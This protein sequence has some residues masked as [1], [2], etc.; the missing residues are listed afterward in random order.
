MK[1]NDDKHLI[2]AYKDMSAYQ[3]PEEFM[4]IQ[5]VD[6]ARIGFMLDLCDG[7][8]KLLHKDESNEE[9]SASPISKESLYSRAMVFLGNREFYKAVDYFD[10][11]LDID[12]QYSRAYW[13]SLL[14][15]YQCVSDNELIN[16][17]ADDW[18]EDARLKNAIQF[19]APEERQI[20]EDIT[21]RRVGNF[22]KLANVALENRDF[23]KCC[24]WCDKYLAQDDMD[25]SVWWLKLLAKNK[26]CNS[27][28]LYD[29]CVRD[30][31][32]IIDSE[33][34]Q[35]AVT[36]SI[37]E[38]A[39]MYENVAKKIEHEGKEKKR[40]NAYEECRSHMLQT[41]ETIRMSRK[42]KVADQWRSSREEFDVINNFKNNKSS[43][44][45]N[46][47]FVFLLNVLFWGVPSYVAI[48]VVMMNNGEFKNFFTVF[49]V[50]FGILMVIVA[51]VHAFK[52][53]SNSSTGPFLAKRCQNVSAK[54][55]N[56][57]KH[58][59]RISAL[60]AKANKLYEQYMTYTDLTFEQIEEKRSEFDEV[61][62][63]PNEDE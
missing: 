57:E 31:V 53:I 22:K 18:T 32:S 34:Y 5:A 27:K 59:A 25:G 48:A 38:E 17:T 26:S 29:S 10:K 55:E 6:M 13:G 3:L 11:V 47:I 15:S 50:L 37:P 14:A 24:Q 46:N 40:N 23:D 4:A 44:Y 30:A 7:V 42:N 45:H 12:P 21:A 39:L 41:I 1:D 63:A 36:Y 33:E 8:K 56:D 43:F 61:C 58:I 16:C 54:I 19:A 60:E 9:V 20:Y 51:M 49:G 52:V 62:T 2:P 28:E 35:K